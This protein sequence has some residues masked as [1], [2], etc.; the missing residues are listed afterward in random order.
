MPCKSSIIII[1]KF[2]GAPLGTLRPLRGGRGRW[3][4]ERG[5][6]GI[7]LL[8][9]ASC[10]SCGAGI[11]EEEEEGYAYEGPVRRVGA[12]GEKGLLAGDAEMDLRRTGSIRDSSPGVERLRNQSAVIKENEFTF[13]VCSVKIPYTLRTAMI[14][15]L[16][17]CCR[18][19]WTPLLRG[20]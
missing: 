5:S 6:R 3:A 20:D 18:L 7:K 16:R 13:A 9:G 2:E 11:E 17:R 12:R 8:P 1:D 15:V 4:R 19:R 14:R 10:D